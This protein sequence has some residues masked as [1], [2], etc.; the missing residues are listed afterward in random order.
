MDEHGPDLLVID[1]LSNFHCGD[2]NVAKDI[3][4]V[5]NVLDSIRA[6][7]VAVAV[8]HHHAKGSTERKN[9]GYKAR[10]S[11]ALPGW[12]DSH[13]SLEWADFSRTVRLEFELRHDEAPE[14]KILKLNPDTLLFELQTDEASQLALVVSVV[15]DFGLL[16]AEAVAD[17]CGRSREWARQWLQRGVEEG[18]LV[19]TGNR[20]V[21]FSIPEDQPPR[22]TVAIPTAHGDHIV[23]STNTGQYGGLHVDA[24]QGGNWLDSH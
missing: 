17:R 8:V 22:T 23:V 6:K 11:S 19:R 20:P 9:I 21:L 1:P 16:E 24:P 14:D 3:L 7:G 4:A 5:T 18:K 13:F 2:E 15:R 10:G 12:Y